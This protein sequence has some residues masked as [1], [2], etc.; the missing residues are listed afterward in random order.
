MTGDRCIKKISISLLKAELI[1]PFRTA[2]GTHDYLENVLLA[3]ELEDGTKGWGEA[4][5]ATHITGETLKQTQDNLDRIKREFIGER[6]DQYLRISNRLLYKQ[7]PLRSWF[8]PC[9][10][11]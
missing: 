10:Q 9:N 6:V 5:V 8:L 11:F 4:A 1:Q 2:L 3:L 7:N